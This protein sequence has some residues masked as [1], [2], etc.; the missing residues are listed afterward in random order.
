MVFPGRVAMAADGQGLLATSPVFRAH[1]GGAGPLPST[2]IGRC[3]TCCRGQDD[4]AAAGRVGRCAAGAV[5]GDGV[6]GGGWRSLGVEPD[7]VVGHSQG[8]IAA[9]YVAGA[10][11]LADAASWWR[12]RPG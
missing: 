1:R 12:A 5:C 8:E 10:L 9:A 4:S 3:A 7:V 2:L 6:A 11:S